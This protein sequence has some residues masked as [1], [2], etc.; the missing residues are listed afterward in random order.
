MGRKGVREFIRSN[1]LGL[2]AIFIALGGTAAATQTGGGLS[3]STSTPSL[4]TRA[5]LQHPLGTAQTARKKK[6]KRGPA[7]PPGP[8]GPQGVQ[9]PPGALGAPATIGP[10]HIVGH[11]G[12]PTFGTGWTQS[13]SAGGQGLVAFRKDSNGQVYLTGWGEFTGSWNG[14]PMF[15]LPAGY[16]PARLTWIPI[17][18]AQTDFVQKAA[19]AS[20]GT[21]IPSGTS[22]SSFAV[23]DGVSF[24]TDA[25]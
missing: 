24:F 8:S 21:V 13:S 17:N 7:G 16:R 18:A 6:S 11:A 1:L 22:S 23:L 14:T 9:G 2:I 3:T 12:E 5:A 25:P 15:T 4:A 10:W 19:I 20:S